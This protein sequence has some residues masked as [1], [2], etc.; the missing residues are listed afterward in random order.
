MRKGFF[1]KITTI[2]MMASVVSLTS[3]DDEDNEVKFVPSFPEAVQTLSDTESC[4]VSFK[5]NDVWT[6]SSDATW[7]IF[8]NGSTTTQGDAGNQEIVVNVT[9]SRE[10]AGKTANITLSYPN[11]PDQIRMV[12]AKISQSPWVN[13]V[14]LVDAEAISVG[15][16]GTT[17]KFNSNVA[18]AAKELPS[19]LSFN[20]KNSLELKEGENEVVIAFVEGEEQTPDKKWNGK[21]E[22]YEEN[23]EAAVASFNIEYTG[24]AAG[25]MIIDIIAPYN[26]RFDATSM[27][28]RYFR[29]MM[30]MKMNV[31]AEGIPF[32]VYA[33]EDV[34]FLHGA[35]SNNKCWI[36]EI[37]AESDFYN[38]EKTDDGYQF[39]I[40]STAMDNEGEVY[41]IPAS[42]YEK[43]DKSVLFDGVEL[44]Y[45]EDKYLVLTWS[46]AAAGSG[47]VEFKDGKTY[48]EIVFE[49]N[50]ELGGMEI[51]MIEAGHALIATIPNFNVEDLENKL[52]SVTLMDINT[53][54]E[55]NLVEEGKVEPMET[56]LTIVTDALM[57]DKFIN[58]TIG[59]TSYF[60]YVYSAE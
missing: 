60:I 50:D 52:M 1:A 56:G 55:I 48:E 3:C 14:K 53:D 10:N 20:G 39:V 16:A 27:E 37:D 17:V 11:D 36:D 31:Y 4:T 9:L 46:K 12:I 5:A 32:N 13:E 41:A 45:I 44:G 8:E 30:D 6:L 49:M 35:I 38:V 19:F 25:E 24:M 23:G 2:A 15:Y 26:W 43:M 22:F 34:V 21:I 59:E 29:E 54:A 18:C 42:V 40:W 28:E 58:V 7:A 51:G 57:A 33:G 47:A